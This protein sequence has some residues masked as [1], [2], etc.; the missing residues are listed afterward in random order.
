MTTRNL[1][2]NVYGK[3][4]VV[5]FSHTVKSNNYWSCLCSCG[6]TKIIREYNLLNGSSKS[7]GCNRGKH[8]LIDLTGQRFGKLTVVSNHKYGRR[9]YWDCVCDCGNT[10]SVVGYELTTKA[11]VSCGCN[12]EYSGKKLRLKDDYTPFRVLYRTYKRGALQRGY[13]F[14]LTLDQFYT[15]T[16]Q[17]CSYCGIPP[18]QKIY[19][20]PEILY[21]GIDR[22]DNDSGYTTT[23]CCAC[24]GAC[25]K[26]KSTLSKNEFIDKITKIYNYINR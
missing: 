21:N 8:K 25:N 7:C 10:R 9:V 22:M 19:E 2:G 24:C 23:N 17:N 4:T 14:Q 16:Q 5:A 11:A 20:Y 18:S 1:T 12:N 3:L 15:L 13:S 6:H 26:L